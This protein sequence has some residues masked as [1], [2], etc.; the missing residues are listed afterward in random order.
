MPA[1]THQRGGP[2][3]N[4]RGRQHQPFEG[5]GV[6]VAGGKQS[7][8]RKA[9]VR[10][11]QRHANTAAQRAQLF[12]DGRKE[13]PA[14]VDQNAENR[15]GNAAHDDKDEEVFGMEFVHENVRP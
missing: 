1:K 13:Q 10:N 4:Q 11:R 15:R 8:H 2:G 5:V 14:H 12:R 7:A 3:K 9:K 6:N